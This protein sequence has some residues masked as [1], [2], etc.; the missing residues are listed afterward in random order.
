MARPI[1]Q[2][3]PKENGDTALGILLPLNKDARGK[4]VVDTYNSS[5]ASGKGVF[6]SS[7]TTEEAVMSNLT[8]L[9]LTTKGQRY[10]QPNFGTNISSVLF[11]N[12]T[13]DVR[14]L[15][16]ETME[17]DIKYWLPYVKLLDVELKGYD[18]YVFM[19]DR[20]KAQV[21]SKDGKWV[22]EHIRTAILKFNYEVDKLE[23][24]KV[25]DFTDKEVIEYEKTFLSG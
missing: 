25:K 5:A 18:H 10:M 20:N 16:K 13:D 22:T 21:V 1:Y 8:N 19:N 4:S 14:E 6:E 15:L 17:D 11:E 3:K 7:Y 23:K 2:Y 24:L 12:N 9:L